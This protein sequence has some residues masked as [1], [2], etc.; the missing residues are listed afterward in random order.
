MAVTKDQQQKAEP[1]PKDKKDVKGGKKDAPVDPDADLSEE[2]LELKKNL[3]LQVQRVSEGDAAAQQAALA[4]IC[5]E[6]QS[7]TSAMSAVP[8]PLKFLVPHFEA[9]K[10]AFEAAKPA[11]AHRAAL[12]DVLSVL[13]STVAGKEG[14][15]D[16]LKFKLAGSKGNLGQWGHEYLRHISGEIAEEFKVVVRDRGRGAVS[17][18][19]CFAGLLCCCL[20]LLADRA[21]TTHFQSITN[22]HH[23]HQTPKPPTHM[24]PNNAHRNRSRRRRR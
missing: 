21:T 8:K 19:F 17:V 20:L 5:A 18:C 15:R 2:D 12:A 22:S 1:G 11:A 4:A 14:A 3:E 7:A 24:E 6:I 23:P 10:A 9:L 16:G 13:A